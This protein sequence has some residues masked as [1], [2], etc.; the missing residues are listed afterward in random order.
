MDNFLRGGNVAEVTDTDRVDHCV[1]HEHSILYHRVVDAHCP[2][3]RECDVGAAELVAFSDGWWLDIVL[4]LIVVQLQRTIVTPK[5]AACR[6]ML[7][8]V[9]VTCMYVYVFI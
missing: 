8:M 7:S 4:S 2:L 6:D 3:G 5:G 1:Q 9:I